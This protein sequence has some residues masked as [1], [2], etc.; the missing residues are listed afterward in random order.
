MVLFDILVN[1][2][3]SIFIDISILNNQIGIANWGITYMDLFKFLYVI[4]VSYIVVW[5]FLIM[6]FK[7]LKKIMQYDKWKGGHK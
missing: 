1:D 4:V 6:P 3:L 7:I 2:I 5:L